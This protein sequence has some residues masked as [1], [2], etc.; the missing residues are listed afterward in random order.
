M[1]NKVLL[2]GG[3]G[4]VG[5]AIAA[6]LQE[7]YQVISTAGHHEPENG[8]CLPVENPERLL[9]ILERENPD[10][11]TSSIRGNFQA[12]IRFHAELAHW[13]KG[14][15]KRLLYVSTVN[16]FDGDLSRP[17][18]EE[19]P[20]SPESD[21]GI[22]KRDCETMLSE[23]LG[24]QLIIF[25]PATIWDFDCPRVRQLNS[26]SCSGELHHT[27]SGIMVN[28][29][30]AKQIGTC[31]KYVLDRNLGGIFHIGTTDTVD[32]FTFE[33]M[34]CETL[35]IKPPKYEVKE[36]SPAVFQ[37]V[38]PARKDIPDDLQMT[39]EQVLKALKQ[40]KQH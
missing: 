26:H 34:I 38:I 2:I 32:Y 12:Q 30:Y 28:V 24:N 3:S 39:I 14:K 27:Y 35:D 13:L 40:Q 22:F 20:P 1:G 29:T 8:Y 37:A 9:Q 21:Y 36:T 15:D 5:K 18:T 16:V 25:R 11:V 19:D 6:A 17:R 7:D 4:L 33:K 23:S 31:A 10:I